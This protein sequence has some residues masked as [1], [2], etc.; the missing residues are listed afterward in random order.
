MRLTDKYDESYLKGR[1]DGYWDAWL[2]IDSIISRTATWGNYACGYSD[3][4]IIFK[5]GGN[6]PK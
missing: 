2:G 5:D 6:L 1:Y 4:Q 3:G